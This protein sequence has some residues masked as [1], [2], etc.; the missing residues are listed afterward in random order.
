V[1]VMSYTSVAGSGSRPPLQQAPARARDGLRAA[2]LA[3]HDALPR[4]T[5]HAARLTG[6]IGFPSP[7]RKR[8]QPD[9]GEPHRSRSHTA[10]RAQDQAGYIGSAPVRRIILRSAV[11]LVLFH[12]LLQERD[13]PSETHVQARVGD[14]IT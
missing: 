1:R 2:C 3:L 8:D 5:S 11:C 7:T 12:N 13:G 4:P 14:D 10:L 6:S 9:L